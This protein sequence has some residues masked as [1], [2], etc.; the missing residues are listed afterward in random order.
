MSN[1]P[2]QTI[3]PVYTPGSEGTEDLE[4]P[5]GKVDSRSAA[6]GDCEKI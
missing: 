6:D 2:N 1:Q 4:G 3:G 5:E